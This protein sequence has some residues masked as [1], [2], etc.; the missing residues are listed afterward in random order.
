MKSYDFNFS[1]A[2]YLNK[3]LVIIFIFPGLVSAMEKAHVWHAI[4]KPEALTSQEL[5]SLTKKL[6]EE[7]KNPKLLGDILNETISS[8]TYKTT[9]ITPAEMK[10]I[11]GYIKKGA[12]VN[13]NRPVRSSTLEYALDIG[14]FEIVK[15]LLDSGA[16]V[17]RK[18]KD[19]RTPLSYYIRGLWRPDVSFKDIINERP[20]INIV[21][22]LLEY[23]AE[24]NSRD[25]LG[26]TAL[27]EAAGRAEPEIIKL[28]LEVPSIL[29]TQQLHAK[30][31]Q[32]YL[33]LLPEELVHMTAQYV[34]R[35][36]PNI[37]DNE[38]KTALNIAIEQL[39]LILKLTLTAADKLEIDQLVNRYQMVINILEPITAKR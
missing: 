23:G 26:R 20:D 28:L 16:N 31:V 14:N 13:Y 15:L 4:K 19:G 34:N 1:S 30:K 39:E 24:V 27:M 33:E 29:L 32:T 38:G 36:N 22:L 3:S 7:A 25:N 5:I 21:R 11:Q 6:S 8:M 37:T 35:P 18:N 17:N 9:A 12:D 10:L 2:Q